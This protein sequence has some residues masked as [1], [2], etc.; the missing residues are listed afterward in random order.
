LTWNSRPRS[1]PN[2][3]ISLCELFRCC[4]IPW[5]IL[6]RWLG[7]H[8]PDLYPTRGFNSVSR[9]SHVD[10]E[11]TPQI[12]LCSLY[13]I[14]TA[15]D[16]LL[17][18]HHHSP[19]SLFP[20]SFLLITP[21]F[22]SL[23]SIVTVQLHHLLSLNSLPW[24]SLHDFT[25]IFCLKIPTC[26][27]PFHLQLFASITPRPASAHALL[28]TAKLWV[29]GMGRAIAVAFSHRVLMHPNA[30]RFVVDVAP[31]PALLNPCF[32]FWYIGRV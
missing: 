19:I 18:L 31:H 17:R 10:L 21:C 32:F 26:N 22:C 3:Q 12:S 7:I 15:L 28:T 24:T 13:L 11:F 5:P 25:Q 30:L 9:T 16:S 20:V 29:L 8:A 27:A 1:V 4:S 23:P 2:V 14:C 6:A